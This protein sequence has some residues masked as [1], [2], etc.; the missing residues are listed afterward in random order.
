[1][2]LFQFF[3]YFFY[4]YIVVLLKVVEGFWHFISILHI[5]ILHFHKRLVQAARFYE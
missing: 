2:A 3:G 5:E 4:S 1:M